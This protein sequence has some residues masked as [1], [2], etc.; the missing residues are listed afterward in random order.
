MITV[1][2]IPI[3]DESGRPSELVITMIEGAKMCPARKRHDTVPWA[4][5]ATKERMTCTEW[6][7]WTVMPESAPGIGAVEAAIQAGY[8][9]KPRGGAP[10]HIYKALRRLTE[11]GI[12]CRRR[13]KGPQVMEYRYWRN[14]RV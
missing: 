13:V 6:R 4:S 1:N 9:R 12:L 11:R 5:R 8:D 14:R 10:D 7:L 2:G 3:L